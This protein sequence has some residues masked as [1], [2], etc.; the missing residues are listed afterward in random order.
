MTKYLEFA[1]VAEANAFIASINATMG[2]PKSAEKTDT[3]T[4]AVQHPTDGRA[5]CAVDGDAET[6]LSSVQLSTLV[7]RAAIEEFFPT[8]GV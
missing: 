4:Q 7:D 5:V 3:Y 2:Y 8:E 1:S 6:H